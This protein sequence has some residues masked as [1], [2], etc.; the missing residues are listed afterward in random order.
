[1]KVVSCGAPY[2]VGGLGLHLAAVVEDARKAGELGRYYSGRPKHGDVAGEGVTSV[3]GTLPMRMP[4]L[5]FRPDWRNH[6]ASVSFDRAVRRRLIPATVF[7][8]FA[9]Q[10]LATMGR[11]KELGCEVLELESPTAHVSHVMRQQTKAEKLG[12][13]R[14]WASD[15]YATRVAR[16]YREADVIY[17]TSRL[18]HD[19]FAAAGVQ[20]A[21]LARRTLSVDPRFIPAAQ[22]RADG[23]FRVVY[24][25]A[26][27]SVKGV[28][29]LIDAFRRMSGAAQLI[30]VGGWATRSMRKHLMRTMSDDPRI[31]IVV[32]DPLPY[33]QDAD[34]YAHA[35][36]QDGF[37][38][39]PMEAMACGVPVIVTE[40]TGMKEH[41]R[42]GV[43]G[44]VVRTG[45]AEDLLERLEHVRR[46]DFRPPPVLDTTTD[47][48]WRQAP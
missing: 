38:Y 16:E 12:I 22:R 39:G 6:V 24:V 4:P 33:L 17:I 44:F 3:A 2:G 42:E 45:E 26:L 37:G 20:S 27:T 19:T 28:P 18:V 8:G 9:G 21:R 7:A 10:A 32:G 47:A 43:D 41:V 13:E 25:G 30:L 15:Q 31:R 34:V 36:F 1:V 35:S 23:V 40:D 14:G 48:P 11:A 29:I 5:R 46:F